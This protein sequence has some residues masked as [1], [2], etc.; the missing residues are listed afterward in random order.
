MKVMTADEFA[1]DVRNILDTIGRDDDEVVIVRDDQTTVRLV[2]TPPRG[3]PAHE[4][5]ARLEGIL[6]PEEGEALLR[7]IRDMDSNFD[8]SIRDPWE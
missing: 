6:T 4:A 1:R 3:M 5:F 2:P 8:Q 7:D